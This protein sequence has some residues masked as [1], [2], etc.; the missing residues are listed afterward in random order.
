MKQIK[1]IFTNII[2]LEK[3]ILQESKKL[4][5]KRNL[6][7]K[8]KK[9]GKKKKFVC[10]DGE[11]GSRNGYPKGIRQLPTYWYQPQSLIFYLGPHINYL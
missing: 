1:N 4:A 7:G 2:S 5:S 9:S 3:K 11:E 10:I 8:W 6:M